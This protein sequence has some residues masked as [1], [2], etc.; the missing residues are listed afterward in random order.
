MERV[1]GYELLAAT[2]HAELVQIV[3]QRLQQG[4]RPYGSPCVL[5]AEIVQ[6]V[7]LGPSLDEVKDQ[8]ARKS[9]EE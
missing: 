9:S 4:W 6:A 1:V 2:S 8:R 5:G 3:N 7:V